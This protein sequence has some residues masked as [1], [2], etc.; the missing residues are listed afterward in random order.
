MTVLYPIRLRNKYMFAFLVLR[1]VL[2]IF[3]YTYNLLKFSENIDSF[4]VNVELSIEL[5]HNKLK[6]QIII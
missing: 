1:C 3:M 5:I 2:Y 4:D 6:N